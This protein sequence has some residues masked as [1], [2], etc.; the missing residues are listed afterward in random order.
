MIS[1]IEGT[2]SA[3]GTDY[4]IVKNNGIGFK[5]LV[6]KSMLA[7][8]ELYKKISL[9]TYLL[10]REDALTLFGFE[11]EKDRDLFVTILGA[12]G[13]GPKTALG[14][15][16]TLSMDMISKAVA[17]EQP[18]IFA[19]VPGVGKK[20]A[21]SLLLH[22]QGKIPTAGTEVLTGVKEIDLEVIEALTALGYSVV[23]AQAALQMIPKEAPKELETRI[24]LALQYFA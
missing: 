4:L 7:G 11:S 17:T 24:K 22:L 21:Q 6:P 1:S 23:E 16:S 10:V 15:I 14:I 9:E 5:V 12:N 19:H 3:I 20:T 13:V 2:V 18:E 8:A